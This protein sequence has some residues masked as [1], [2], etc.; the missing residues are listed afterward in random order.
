MSCCPIQ[1]EMR[2]LQKTFRDISDYYKT[3]FNWI[4]YKDN[5]KDEIKKI[6]LPRIIKENHGRNN[7]LHL[8]VV[9]DQD[10]V[11]PIIT[12]NS[13]HSKV[14]E[15]LHPCNL[16]HF[17]S[18]ICQENLCMKTIYTKN[19]GHIQLFKF[20]MIPSSFEKKLVSKILEINAADFTRNE[21]EKLNSDDP[22]ESLKSISEKMSISKD[23]LIQQ[24]VNHEWFASE[25]WYQQL[26]ELL[27]RWNN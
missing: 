11:E 24:S 12:L 25:K 9:L 22:H 14:L 27:T 21:K 2:E 10:Y 23:E 8:L 18:E 26:E 4:V 13:I 1:S 15:I 17:Q 6:V 19:A 7:C 5:G 20:L 16:P 3:T